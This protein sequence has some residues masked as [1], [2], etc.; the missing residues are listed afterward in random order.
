[1]VTVADA[2]RSWSNAVEHYF[3]KQVA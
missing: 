2:E 1:V 3:A